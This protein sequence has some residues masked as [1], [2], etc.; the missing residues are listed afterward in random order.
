MEE[1]REGLKKLNVLPRYETTARGF[2]PTGRG[3]TP[4]AALLNYKRIRP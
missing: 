4:S 2:Q 3:R 1:G